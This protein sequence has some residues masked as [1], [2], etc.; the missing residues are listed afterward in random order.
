MT[1]RD[2]CYDTLSRV[3][4]APDPMT[5]LRDGVAVAECRNGLEAYE[6]L[7]DHTTHGA[8]RAILSGE[9][10]VAIHRDGRSRT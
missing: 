2:L 5:V 6:Y 10:N 8:A 9:W 7:L 3:W 1:A 4:A